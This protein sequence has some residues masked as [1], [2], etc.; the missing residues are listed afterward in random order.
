MGNPTLE[1]DKI[2]HQL[3]LTKSKVVVCSKDYL[4]KYKC[5]KSDITALVVLDDD[6]K[7][8]LIDD[9]LS[10]Q[11][12][13]EI[14]SKEFEPT[15]EMFKA[16]VE[17]PAII[18]WTSGSTGTPKGIVHTQKMLLELDLVDCLN[19][20]RALISTLMYHAGGF[21]FPIYLGIKKEKSVGFITEFEPK[22]F[23]SQIA[24]FK[25]EFVICSSYV[26]IGIGNE[27]DSKQ[28][29]PCMK[30]ILPLGGAFKDETHDR[31]LSVLGMHVAI[32][33]VYGSSETYLITLSTGDSK[34]EFGLCG[35][36]LPGCQLYIADI[37]SGEKLGPNILGKIMI[38]T[39]TLLKSYLKNP[40]AD[41]DFFHADGFGYLGDIGYY[42]EQGDIYYSY[43]SKEILRV[44]SVWF[45]P[46]DIEY[47]IESQDVVKEAVVWGDYDH[48]SG[49]DKV[50]LA[51]VFHDDVSIPFTKSDI[52]KL[53]E[54][55]LIKEMQITG[56]IYFVK[57]IPHGPLMK[58][59]RT[60]MKDIVKSI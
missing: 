56:E 42:T 14:S 4:D 38:K 25:A 18:L 32:E 51:V 23:L 29:F 2:E 9:I 39:P 48:D 13:L 27:K 58:K 15:D 54:G 47:L 22:N 30:K 16:D 28:E 1:N 12:I 40:E 6:S 43:R 53:V 33:L 60:K 34:R 3:Q 21:A 20:K 31:A 11:K 55:K 5:L 52:K 46:V 41:K 10:L 45:S 36:L 35:N 59:L 24:S 19:S 44:N 50:Y 26:Y 49:N 57:D 17:D 8:D 7:D 37:E